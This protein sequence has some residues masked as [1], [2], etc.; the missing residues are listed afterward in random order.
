MIQHIPDRLHLRKDQTSLRRLKV[1]RHDQHDQVS[2]ADQITDQRGRRKKIIRTIFDQSLFEIRKESLSLLLPDA[3]DGDNG[4]DAI[5]FQMLQKLRI[6]SPDVAFVDD[7]DNR[8]FPGLCLRKKTFFRFSPVPR[9]A[10]NN[11]NICAVEHFAAFPDSQFSEFRPVVDSGCIKKNHRSDREQ[12]HRFFHHIGR[13]SRAG[14]GD[15][16]ILSGNQVQKTGFPDIGP[17]E[18]CYL[19][20]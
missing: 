10:E 17:A 20:S 14:G 5:L 19:K 7:N 2:R 11:D 1:D 4:A 6:R 16:H 9:L 8:S 18:Q 15:R 12:F 13:C 3:A